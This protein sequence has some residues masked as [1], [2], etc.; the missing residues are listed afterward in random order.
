[1]NPQSWNLY[2]YVGNNPVNRVDP[3]GE[4]WHIV[5]GVI[6]GAAVGGGIELVSQIARG[7][8]VNMRDIG[9]A[10]L[11]GAIV[12]GVATATGGLGLIT[13]AGGVGIANVVGGVAERGLDSREETKAFDRDAALVDL[14]SG[15]AAGAAQS[16]TTS[17]VEKA[18]EGSQGQKSLAKQAD[19]AVRAAKNRSAARQQPAKDISKRVAERP[20][21]VAKMA[22]T[23]A[24]GGTMAGATKAAESLVKKKEEKE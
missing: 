14:A 15:V 19:H 23:V 7:E 17:K 6:G 12:G 18:I 10:S 4:F 13:E 20:K 9:A 8:D 16:V 21:N 1:M 5:A 2:G 11:K 22:G 3:D 24:R